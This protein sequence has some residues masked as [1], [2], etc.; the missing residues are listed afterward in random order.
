M[1]EKTIMMLAI[2]ELIEV[3][4][5]HQQSIKKQKNQKFQQL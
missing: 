5:I 3:M 2:I 4:F 1:T